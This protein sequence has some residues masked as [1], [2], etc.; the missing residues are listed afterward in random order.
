LKQLP[1]EG[2]GGP[3]PLPPL[4]GPLEFMR[5]LWAID[6]GLQRHS[7]RMEA[8]LGMTGPQRLAVRM[9]GRFPGISA[10]RLARLLHLHP[11][12]LTGILRRLERRGLLRRRRDPRDGRRAVL[13]LSASGRLLDVETA[14]TIESEVKGLLARLP[15]QEVQTTGRV[16][17]ALAGHLDT[18]PAGAPDRR[19]I[20]R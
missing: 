1:P 3:A 8:T 14:G 13:G 9:V 7:K 6:H 16:L 19:R 15:R 2:A 20:R 5:L 12:T 4:G 17:A 10:G 11:S 18:S